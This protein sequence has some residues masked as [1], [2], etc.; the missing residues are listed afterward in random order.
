MANTMHMH[1]ASGPF[2]PLA[3]LMVEAVA[4]VM[5]GFRGLTINPITKL[6][7]LQARSDARRHLLDMEDRLLTDIGLSRADAIN[8][9]RKPVWKA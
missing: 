1:A 5:D 3:S 4:S 8:E 7:E 9:A 6:V 2:A